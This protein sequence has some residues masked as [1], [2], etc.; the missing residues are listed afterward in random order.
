MRR[1]YLSLSHT[2]EIIQSTAK[3]FAVIPDGFVQDKIALYLFQ[4]E[5]S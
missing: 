3:S 5:I 1:Q 4:G 2:A